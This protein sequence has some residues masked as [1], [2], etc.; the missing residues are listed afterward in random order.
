[1]PHLKTAAASCV[2]RMEAPKSTLLLS[3][4]A[5]IHT[6]IQKSP[7]SHVCFTVLLSRITVL[8]T[9]H[10]S[11][12]LGLLLSAPLLPTQHILAKATLPFLCIG[13]MRQIELQAHTGLNS[14]LSHHPGPS[15]KSSPSWQRVS[16]LPLFPYKGMA[17]SP[18]YHI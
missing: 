2:A 7:P 13:L 9:S 16:S 17:R 5:Q 11:V 12:Y 3:L 15:S 6:G 18:L 8:V 10:D 1:M 14:L 4:P